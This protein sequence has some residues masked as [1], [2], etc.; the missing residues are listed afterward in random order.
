MTIDK[1]LNLILLPKMKLSGEWIAQGST[2]STLLP[3][4]RPKPQLE[5]DV[6]LVEEWSLCTL[7]CRSLELSGNSS[8]LQK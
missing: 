1:G 6:W 8:D 3:K 2:L 5:C 4:S 7:V